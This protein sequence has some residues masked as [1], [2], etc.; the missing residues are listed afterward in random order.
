[1]GIFPGRT[2]APPRL[3][4]HPMM[5]ARGLHTGS[6]ATRPAEFQAGR[7]PDAPTGGKCPPGPAAERDRRG[8]RTGGGRKARDRLVRGDE[9][10]RSTPTVAPVYAGRAV[11]RSPAAE[12]LPDGP[13]QPPTARRRAGRQDRNRCDAS[14]VWG[15]RMGCRFFCA[16]GW[17]A[18]RAKPFGPS[19]PWDLHAAG[20]LTGCSFLEFL[21]YT[22]PRSATDVGMKQPFDWAAGARTP[23]R[24]R[25][26]WGGDIRQRSNVHGVSHVDERLMM[27]RESDR[28]YVMTAK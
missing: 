28:R 4:M 24:P 21:R 7:W 11:R 9:S 25:R 6:S 2:H 8:D 18:G 1:M 13:N 27:L 20:R 23:A 15:E 10:S 12:F 3:L 19:S 22:P 26:R 5:L 14:S 17:V 16:P